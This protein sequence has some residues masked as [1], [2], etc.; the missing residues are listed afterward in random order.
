MKYLSRILILAL[1]LAAVL[2]CFVA[3]DGGEASEDTTAPAEGEI[4]EFVDLAATVKFDPNSGRVYTEATVKITSAL[5]EQN[6]NQL[7][8]LAQE[9]LK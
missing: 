4:G 5:N 9:L 2:S 8:T 1:A 3:C 6:L 7:E